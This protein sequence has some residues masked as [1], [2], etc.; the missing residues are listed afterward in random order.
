MEWALAHF[1]CFRVQIMDL[2]GQ[3]ES[4]IESLVEQEGYELVHVEFLERGQ[5]S[6]LRI[7]IDKPG[8]VNLSD[9]QR[10]SRQVGVLL[11]VEEIVPH[12]YTL[13]VSSPGIERPLFKEADFTRFAGSE[14]RLTTVEKINQRRNFVGVLLGCVGGEVEL[15]CEGETVRIP[16]ERVKKAHLVYDFGGGR[17]S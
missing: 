3:V 6:L 8:G 5:A 14:I 7:Y 13:E 10:I 16:L 9:C 15:E 4:L 12:H 1:F 17:P 11:D 2:A